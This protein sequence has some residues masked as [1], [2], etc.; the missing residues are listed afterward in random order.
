VARD[1]KIRE[2]ACITSEEFNTIL[3]QIPE[4]R[5]EIVLRYKHE[6]GRKE[7]ALSYVL[8]CEL[9]K[10]NYGVNEMPVFVYGEHGKPRLEGH[11]N[12]H[13]NMSHCKEAVA[14][15]V[16]DEDVGVD[17]ECLGRLYDRNGNLR[18]S[19]ARYT[20]SDEEYNTVMNSDD[21]DAEFSMLWTKKEAL[22]KL[23]GEGITNDI[24]TVLYK[25]NNV[26]ISTELIKEKGYAISIAQYK[27][28]GI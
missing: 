21:P 4:W 2:L 27:E 28:K 17:I 19:L 26:E 25:Y 15:V 7:S 9:L 11:E 12:I 22:L 5:R 20:L 24:K 1:C 14:C 6:Q 18:D 8:L 10:E 13:F 3:S 23:T 16:S